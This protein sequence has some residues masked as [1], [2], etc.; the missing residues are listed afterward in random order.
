MLTAVIG[1]AADGNPLDI[2]LT[3]IV[4]TSIKSIVVS[5]LIVRVWIDSVNTSTNRPVYVYGGI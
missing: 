4:A 1:V 2:A 5:I 3:L